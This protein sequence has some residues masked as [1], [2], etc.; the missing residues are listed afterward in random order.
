MAKEWAK[1]FYNSKQ[2]LKCRAE[3]KEK[4]FGLCERCE[5]PGSVVHHKSYLTPENI[6][7]AYVT[8]NHDNLELLC[9]DCHNKEHEFNREKKKTVIEGLKFNEVGELIK[10]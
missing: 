7:D 5:E 4:V 2:W 10:K 3:Y 9:D 6:N 1:K 8:L